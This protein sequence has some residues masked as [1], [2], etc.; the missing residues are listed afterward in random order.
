MITPDELVKREVIYCVSTLIYELREVA[1]RLDDYD[2]YLTLTG[3]V[4]Q[5]EEAATYF[6]EQDA[7]FDQLVAIV[8]EYDSDDLNLDL[9]FRKAVVD[10]VDKQDD[11]FQWVCSEYNLEPEYSDIYEHWIVTGWLGDKLR[12]HGQVVE[13]YLGLTIWGRPTTGQSISMDWVI[14]QIC[15]EMN[16]D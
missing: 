15:K 5:Y 8:A 10:L 2:T 11:C 4:P 6:I 16:D 7:D 3:G 1:K 12:E 9:P 14:E 13:E